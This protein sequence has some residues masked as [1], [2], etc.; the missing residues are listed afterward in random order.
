VKALAAATP[1]VNKSRKRG[2]AKYK[3]ADMDYEMSE[4]DNLFV[5]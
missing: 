2:A 3:E 1:S 4:E 5:K